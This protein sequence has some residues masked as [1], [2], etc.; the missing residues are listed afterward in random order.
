MQEPQRCGAHARQAGRPCRNWA[1]PNG[2]CRM[3]G[4]KS[5][6]PP[7]GSQNAL[8]HG[9]HAAAT[10]ERRRA[11]RALLKDVEAELPGGG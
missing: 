6:G 7:K 8:K 10:V 5:P 9:N 2:R 11:L 4:G 1:M 3:H